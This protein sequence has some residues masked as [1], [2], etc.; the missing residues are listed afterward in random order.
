MP[1]SETEAETLERLEAA[2]RKIAGAAH[3]PVNVAPD[4]AALTAALDKAI[5]RLRAGLNPAPPNS[6]E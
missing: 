1:E 3:R 4:R 6:K 5:S 2:L